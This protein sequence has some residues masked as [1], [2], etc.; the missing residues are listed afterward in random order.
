M[1][2]Q[3]GAVAPQSFIRLLNVVPDSRWLAGGGPGAVAT[4]GPGG[5]VAVKSA[6][7]DA[8]SVPGSIWKNKNRFVGA[9]IAVELPSAVWMPLT[10][11]RVL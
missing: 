2:W 3:L 6:A 11:F 8:D 10:L 9:S 5:A 1:F 7:M 4:A